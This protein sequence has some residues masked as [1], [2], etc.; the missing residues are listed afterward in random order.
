MSVHLSVWFSLCQRFYPA[1][2]LPAPA[3]ARCTASPS[4]SGSL[5]PSLPLPP[6]L[7]SL[8][9]CPVTSWRE[10]MCIHQQRPVDFVPFSQN[11]PCTN[12]RPFLYFTM[13]MVL[14][15]VHPFYVVSGSLPCCLFP[16]L[17]GPWP[18]LVSGDGWEWRNACY[19]SVVH[20]PVVRDAFLTQ[21]PM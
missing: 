4:S 18:W 15:C 12:L 3:V 19:L 10:R 2:F 8:A 9:G 17:P 13:Y 1:A 11:F 7:P 5:P 14:S 6:P 16:C 21:V 20:Q